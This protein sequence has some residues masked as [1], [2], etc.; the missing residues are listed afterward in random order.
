M[1]MSPKSAKTGQTRQLMCGPSTKNTCLMSPP[2]APYNTAHHVPIIS[3]RSRYVRMPSGM[4]LS[5][6]D[7]SGGLQSGADSAHGKV[8]PTRTR[9]GTSVSVSPRVGGTMQH[10]PTG[11]MLSTRDGA[12]QGEMDERWT[13]HILE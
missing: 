13:R 8:W 10:L 1:R 7:R 9:N 5:Q 6:S 4:L 11:P 3:H 12:R 2:K